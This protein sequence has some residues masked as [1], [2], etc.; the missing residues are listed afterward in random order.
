M[1]PELEIDSYDLK[2]YNHKK[3][4]INTKLMKIVRTKAVVLLVVKNVCLIY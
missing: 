1:K 2:E 4:K 3:S